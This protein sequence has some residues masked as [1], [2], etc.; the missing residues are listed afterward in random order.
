MTLLPKEPKA[1]VAA[2]LD[3][4]ETGARSGEPR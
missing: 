4:A 3:Y 2:L 1:A